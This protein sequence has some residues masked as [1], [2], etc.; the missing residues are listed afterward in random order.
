MR[1]F[2]WRSGF[3]RKIL[4]A[5]AII[6]WEWLWY[7][8]LPLLVFVGCVGMATLFG[9]FALFPRII[10]FVILAALALTFLWTLRPLLSLTLPTR[11]DALRRLEKS[12]GLAHRPAS[13]YED[14]LAQSFTDRS[15][16]AVWQAHKRQLRERLSQ[17][18]TGW[19]HPG[20]PARDPLGLRAIIVLGLVVAFTWA[21]PD[22][23]DRIKEALAPVPSAQS[24]SKTFIDAWIT[25]PQ[26]TGRA[27]VF[28]SGANATLDSETADRPVDV[29]ANSELVIRV[30]GAKELKAVINAADIVGRQADKPVAF[31]ET[32][33]QIKTA[34]VHL[35][36]SG[37]ALISDGGS[38]LAAWRFNVIPDRTPVI[39][40][41]SDQPLTNEQAVQFGYKLNDDYGVIS[42][43]A[44][45]KLA[46]AEDGT[47]DAPRYALPVTPPDFALVL[48]KSRV[49]TTNQKVYRDFTSHP[50]AGLEVSLV[51][52]ATDEA[53]Q[54][55]V[56]EPVRL[57]LPERNFQKPLARAFIE[58]RKRLV[59]EEGAAAKVATA[60]GG[61]MIVAPSLE[62]NSVVYLGL[63]TAH[64]RLKRHDDVATSTEMVDLLWDLA[65]RVEDGDLS[66]AERELRAAQ[67]AL[68]KAI[69][70][71]APQEEIDRLA[72]ELRKALNRFME[73]MAE[74]MR[75]NAGKNGGKPQQMPPD[76]QTITPQ[77]LAKMMDMIENLLK[78]GA[79]DAA[80]EMLA[81]LNEIL[82]NMQKGQAVTGSQER[83]E[84]SEMLDKLGDMMGKQQGLMD[85]T[86]QSSR[87]K[88]GQQQGQGQ[89]GGQR[90][91]DLAGQQETLR[92]MLGEF[93]KQFQ[94]GNQNGPSA[95]G[96]AGQAMRD[97]AEALRKG[98]NKQA[99][100]RQGEAI[101]QMRQGANA[102]A[103]EMLQGFGQAN[104]NGQ[105]GR[106][107]GA[108]DVDPLGRSMRTHG[109]DLGT[110]TKVP[111]EIEVQRAREIMR[112]LQR[113]LGERSR[114]DIEL[115]YIE[116]L[117]KRF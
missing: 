49:K 18:K 72:K 103:R 55:G 62:L 7:A 39:S 64:H 50:W 76:A 23:S 90:D 89:Q 77:D 24:A 8:L 43:K 9:V 98:Q 57:V 106:K 59:S 60:L 99:V 108:G 15:S 27:P 44:E 100:G 70:D 1:N 33:E 31:Q 68:R 52:K 93:M 35:L 66:L 116:R 71:N 113:R 84:L 22:T 102:M 51:L 96:R 67:E 80:Q 45:F 40:I 101:D 114:P 20:L 110:S 85:E 104:R 17:L 29:P 82:E 65:L 5:R 16:R 36:Q 28:L 34:R 2:P 109:P 6:F 115:D 97:A 88:S 38:E 42:G 47:D 3:E 48:P 112:E 53:E 92:E 78:N 21:G 75:Q 81:Q 117:L 41:D 105:R 13:S 25:P 73:A 83:S 94:N 91:S 95:L 61:L 19:P 107:R 54:T 87:E 14:T 26:Y 74:Q 46:P 32:G 12:S 79:T 10:H 111:G 58:Q 4:T 56:S 11:E 86:F 37:Q 69:A 30:T 63:S